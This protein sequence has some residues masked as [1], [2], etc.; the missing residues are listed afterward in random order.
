M[1]VDSICAIWNT[2]ASKHSTAD[3]DGT[4]FDSPRAGGKYFISGTAESVLE[5]RTC[6]VKALLTTWLVEQRKFGDDCPKIFDTTIKIIAGREALEVGTKVDRVLHF[7]S[8]Q[9]KTPGSDVKLF[10]WHGYSN[11]SFEMSEDAKNYYEILAQ[12][13]CLN[14]NELLFILEFLEQSGWITYTE[15]TGQIICKLTV[16]GYI[17]IVEQKK[18]H[19]D[20]DRSF[21]AMWFD[22]SMNDAWN[23]GFALAIQHAGYIPVRIDRQEF[24]NRIDDEIIAE[25]RKAKFVIADFTQGNTGARGGVYYEAGFAHGLNIPVLFTCRDDSIKEVHFDTRQFNHIVWQTSDE[26]H[27]KLIKRIVAVIG[28]GPN[29]IPN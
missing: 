14:L 2:P 15:T 12:C 7:L 28:Q 9:T 11:S 26:L 19:V 5:N 8:A 4:K 17:Q 16:D 21:V 10:H 22:D 6:D 13:E 25:I 3:E 18:T 24:A 1:K 27:S 29:S 20:S 23:N